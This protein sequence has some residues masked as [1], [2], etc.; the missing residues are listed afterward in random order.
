M[1]KIL[2]LFSLFSS[3]MLAAPQSLAQS[4]EWVETLGAKIRVHYEALDGDAP[5]RAI[6]DVELEPGWKTYWLDPGANGIP[7]QVQMISSSGEAV[8]SALVFPAPV[9]LHAGGDS[10]AGYDQKLRL[11]IIPDDNE[12]N[13][14]LPAKMSVFLGLCSDI[15]V[16]FQTEFN[17]KAPAT[18][19]AKKLTSFYL[20]KGFSEMPI[21]MAEPLSPV[22]ID[23]Q[24]MLL[25]FDIDTNH[26]TELF[27]SGIGGW[28][29]KTPR[30]MT[31]E[32]DQPTQ[33]QI[34]II[35]QGSINTLLPFTLVDKTAG[36]AISG[37]ITIK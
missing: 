4:S 25:E 32:S 12:E 26:D 2:A 3:V 7:P 6:L 8:A 19:S 28:L 31:S 21:S 9:W 27:I 37:S 11:G 30:M 17:F 34:P 35:A 10:F 15:C 16:P 33:F 1:K 14:T 29:F 5:W 22:T 18:E 23:A 24:M 13:S 36:T 20:D